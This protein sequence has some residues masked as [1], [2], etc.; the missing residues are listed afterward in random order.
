[1]ESQERLRALHLT[2]SPHDGNPVSTQQLMEE[3]DCSRS[4]LH[5]TVVRLRDSY[6]APVLNSP[7]RGYFYDRS[8]DS[9]ELPG[10]WFRAD[11]LEALLVSSSRRCGAKPRSRGRGLSQ[12]ASW[13]IANLRRR[14]VRIPLVPRIA[15]GLLNETWV[16]NLVVLEMVPSEMKPPNHRSAWRYQGSGPG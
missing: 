10:L 13:P 9:F 7:G 5:R 6:G 11:E 12:F 1:M 15:E 14:R 16:W 2:R 4:T 3:L 8:A